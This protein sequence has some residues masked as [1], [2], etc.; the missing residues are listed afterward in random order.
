[1]GKTYRKE[2]PYKKAREAADEATHGKNVD[3][4]HER[5]VNRRRLRDTVTHWNHDGD[6]LESLDQD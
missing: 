4:D 3:H 5:T 2:K 1:M 6:D